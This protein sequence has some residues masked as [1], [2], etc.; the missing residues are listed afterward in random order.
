MNQ[1]A[2]RFMALVDAC[3]LAGALRRNMT[4]SLAE[5]VCSCLDGAR[6]I[7]MEHTEI[8]KGTTDGTR[9]RATINLAFPEAIV[10]GYGVV[11]GKLDLPGPYCNHVLAAAISTSASH[12]RHDP[13]FHGAEAWRD[14]TTDRLHF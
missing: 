11:E 14:L 1:Y 7:S 9:K 12:N 13:R 10:F 4:S 8:T 5:A 3:V 6:T 2:D